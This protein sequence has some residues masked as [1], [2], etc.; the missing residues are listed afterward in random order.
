M[1][2][3]IVPQGPNHAESKTKLPRECDVLVNQGAV[4]KGIMLS[5][6]PDTELIS[7][8]P[9]SLQANKSSVSSMAPLLVRASGIGYIAP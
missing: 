8:I 5:S 9:L 6:T 2:Q 3:D 7:S 1:H 4:L